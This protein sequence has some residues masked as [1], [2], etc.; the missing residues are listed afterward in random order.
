MQKGRM[1]FNIIIII[2]IV[3]LI[4]VIGYVS[5]YYISNYFDLKNAEEAVEQFEKEV[6]VVELEDE[7]QNE[8]II[9]EPVNKEEQKP[10]QNTNNKNN[11]TS[12]S[13]YYKGYT[14]IGTIQ[15]TK[16][17]VKIP[18]VDKVTPESITAAAAVLYG[19][20]LNEI[21]NTVLVAH[22]YRNRN[23]LF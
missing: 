12:K 18:I 16:T 4:S 5:Y 17:K 11:S 10:I 19:P 3:A 13:T 7:G 14:M 6:I 23:F 20:G 22:N 1:F 9:E 2:T 8:N 21:G 15:I